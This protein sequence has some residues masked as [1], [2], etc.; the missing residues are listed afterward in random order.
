MKMDVIAA[1]DV[2][3]LLAQRGKHREMYERVFALKADEALRLTCADADEANKLTL[4]LRNRL[5]DV[6]KLPK[7]DPRRWL[8]VKNSTALTVTVVQDPAP[9]AAAKKG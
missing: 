1:A 7:G 4:A 2:V 6:A 8:V 9:P 3:I 5:T